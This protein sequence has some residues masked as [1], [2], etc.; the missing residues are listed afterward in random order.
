MNITSLNLHPTKLKQFQKKGIDTVE[1]LLSFIPR[2]YV[3]Y[4]NPKCFNEFSD[5]ADVALEAT[6]I[7]MQYN[8]QKHYWKGLVLERYCCMRC[9]DFLRQIFLK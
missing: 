9:A 5:G 8:N 3:D 4:R 7:T 6:V 2:R 1:N